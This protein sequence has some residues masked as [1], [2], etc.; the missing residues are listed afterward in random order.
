MSDRVFVTDREL[1]RTFDGGSYPNAWEAVQQYREA[2]RYSSRHD[3]GSGATASALELPRSR[4]RTWIDDGGKPDVVR[5][6]DRA[7]A[8]GW[9]DLTYDDPVFNGLNALVADVFSGGSI[10]K[11]TYSPSFTINHRGEDSHVFDALDLVGVE[12]KIIRETEQGRATEARP[13][14]HGTVLGR[15]LVTLGAPLGPK[16]EQRLE[17]PGYLDGAPDDVKR[18]FVVC[19]LENRARE[20]ETKAT[21]QV[22]ENR[23]RSYHEQMASLIADVT[24]ERVTAE[25]RGFTISA[26]AARE[27]GTVR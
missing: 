26:A 15:V 24:G 22:H 8:N 21:L 17:L 18:L 27:L 12:Y 11:E 4:L 5:C 9:L 3:V 19:Y 14:A 6:I 2:T 25:D 13:S 23:N 16:A 7:R 1:A 10:A 20:F